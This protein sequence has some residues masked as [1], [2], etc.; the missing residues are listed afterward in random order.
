METRVVRM[1]QDNRDWGYRRIQGALANWGHD[2]SHGIMANMVKQQGIEPAPERIRKTTGK[3]FLARHW[4]QIVATG[5]FTIELWTRTGLQRFLVLFLMELSTR[6]VKVGGIAKGANGFWMS[7]IARNLSDAVDGCFLGKRYLMQDRDP[8]YTTEF[9][10]M[11]A[12]VGVK[13]VKL[14]P[15]SPNLNAYAERF[16]RTIKEGCLERMILFGE[17]SWRTAISEFLSHDHLERNHQGLENR[18]IAPRNTT[19]EIPGTV[20]RRQRRGGMLH[21]YYREAV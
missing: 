21:Y 1:A 6:R 11:L 16:V 3:E 2:L 20:Q 13:S 15:R 10:S 7:Q 8:L 9:L 12:D 17:G 14:P 5:L 19:I 18:L 4:E